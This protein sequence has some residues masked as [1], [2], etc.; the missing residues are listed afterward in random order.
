MFQSISGRLPKRGRQRRE[1]IDESKLSKQTPSVPTAGAG[2][3]CPI[4]IQIIGR[5]STESLPRA[6]AP[7]EGDNKYMYVSVKI[8]STKQATLSVSNSFKITVDSRYVEVEGT[9]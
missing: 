4:I 9:L 7:A 1:R 3:P 5:P 8:M 2:G 6:I